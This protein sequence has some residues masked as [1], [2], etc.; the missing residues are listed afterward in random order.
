M[1][2]LAAALVLA[3]IPVLSPSAHAQGISVE[4]LVDWGDGA[5]LWGSADLPPEN[6]TALK[7]LELALPFLHL[8]VTW[9]DSPFCV[10]RP[11]AFLDD[12][13]DADPVYPL[14]WHFNV[15]NR[16]SKRWNLAPVGPSDS[17][18]SDGDAIGF[19]LTADD[20]QTFAAPRPVPT[21]DF[22]L[23]WTSFRGDVRNAGVAQGL[24]PVTNRVLWSYALNPT[25]DPPPEVD[26]TP[27]AAYGMVFVGTRN[28]FVA[29]DAATGE[30]VWRNSSL[31]VLLSTPAIYD[32]HL[33]V[34]GTDGRLHYVDAFTG[35]GDWSLLL[36]PGAQSTGIASSPTIFR[37]R[38]Y[39]GTF[40]ESGGPGRVVAVNLNNGTFAWS[41]ETGSIHMSQPVIRGDRLYVGVMGTYDGSVS[42]SPPY[43]L[44]CLSLD[45]SLMWF[46]ET[47]GPVASSP[48]VGR[49]FLFGD[50]VYFTS[51]D[52][53]LY[54]VFDQGTLYFSREIGPS[55][56]SPALPDDGLLGELYVAA[57]GL[58]GTGTLYRMAMNGEI[59]WQVSV[60]GGI[61]ASP[62]ASAALVCAATNAAVGQHFCVRRSDGAMVWSRQA[63]SYILGSMSVVRTTLYA[64]S[65]AGAVFAFRDASPSDY[66]L[67]GLD[68][69]LE[70][71]E[72]LRVAVSSLGRGLAIDVLISVTLPAGFRLA[73]ETAASARSSRTFT[74]PL[75]EMDGVEVVEFEGT[76]ER[77]GGFQF[78]AT[79]TYSDLAS[80]TYP[81]LR[82]DVGFS[83]EP[84]VAIPWAVA[85]ATVGAALVLVTWF[86]VWRRRGR[87]G[88]HDR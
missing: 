56:S 43:G 40:N 78:V 27:V 2:M 13:G 60:A 74:F 6:V 81:I 3:A 44:L 73:N 67:L 86:L 28:Q 15:W 18:L 31:H 48:V 55:T 62:V 5:A 69:S 51:K 54:G 34:G 8:E 37:G 66:P 36:Q 9:Y 11:C 58:D 20:P 26:V 32:G 49:T 50:V 39:V 45:G 29:L 41:Y 77:F 61:Q 30:L 1:A 46:F 63:G 7:A 70:N 14:W 85:L 38:A 23:V 72:R 57:G 42:Y 76:Y 22:P 10:R 25:S 71:P 12:I 64:V 83:V 65:D 33:V 53:F 24:I 35:D 16:T 47:A 4:V 88:R 82:S 75:D 17:D 68:V 19:Y 79:A 52:G 84:P 21:P 87:R 80:R 59:Q